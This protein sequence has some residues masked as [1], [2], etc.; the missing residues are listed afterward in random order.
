MYNNFLSQEEITV[1]NFASKKYKVIIELLNDQMQTI[2]EIQGDVID[3]SFSID[4]TSD[5]RRTCN[6][7]IV[8]SNEKFTDE[9]SRIWLDKYVRITIS[10]YFEP[11]DRLLPKVFGTLQFTDVSFS[12]SINTDTISISC[13]D[14]MASLTGDLMGKIEKY[15]TEIPVDSNIREVIVSTLTQLGGISSF[16]VDEDDNEEYRTVPYTLT[17]G[18]DISVYD[19]LKKILDLYPGWEMFFDPSGT[20]IYQKI[21]TAEYDIDFINDDV[22]SG[23][24][25]G[26]SMAYDF[27]QIKNCIQ[28]FGNSNLLGENS[29]R[30]KLVNEL[31]EEP[32]PEISYIV[33]PESPFSIEKIGE[34]LNILSGGDYEYIYSMDLL[35]QRAEYELW[36]STNMNHT[37]NFESILI[38]W[39]DVNK[40]FTHKNKSTGSTEQYITKNISF[41]LSTSS[42]TMSVSSIKFYPLYPHLI[43]K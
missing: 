6:L 26:E 21:P 1:L 33:N 10:T 38:P 11:E 12:K 34:R 35:L 19:I 24:I 43:S 7:T 14:M 15:F 23:L 22:L 30:I 20:F 40:K 25:I 42:A 2:D 41:D 8:N 37:L 36:L 32:D 39:M 18:T 28:I 9:S 27:K 16:I 3:G 4:A 29:V 13:V 17:F 5:L 31:P